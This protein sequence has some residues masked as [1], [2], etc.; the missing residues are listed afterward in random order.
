MNMETTVTL[1]GVPETMLWTLYNRA[2]E[3]L[4]P[5]ALIRD[6]ECVRIYSSIE[7]D[8]A[9]SFGRPDGS[10]PMRSRIFDDALKPWLAAHPGGSVVELACGLETQF[11]RCDDGRVRWLCVDLPESIAV[12]ERFLPQTDRC[13]YIEKDVF[14]ATWMDAVDPSRGVFVTAQGVFPYYREDEAR[15]VIVAVIDRFPGVEIMFDVIPRWF[16]RK[17][18]RGFRKTAHYTSPAMPWGIGRDEIEPLMR[19]WSPR[20]SE[21]RLA[22]YGAFRGLPG[23]MLRTASRLPW[24][25]NITPM[26]VD[27]RTKGDERDGVRR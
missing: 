25:R 15:R 8:F 21:V 27:I 23:A 7:Y 26:I 22:P 2:E 11:Q 18:V 17:T 6:P 9:R 14:D 19:A 12:R 4:R 3:A 10:H 13:R 1:S 20:V 24:A 16:S 5:D